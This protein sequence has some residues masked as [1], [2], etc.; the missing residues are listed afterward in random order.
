MNIIPAIDM[1]NGKCVRLYKGDYDQ[2]T[3]YGEDPVAMAK[4]F[5]AVGAKVLHLVDLDAAREQGNNRQTIK[6]I[7]ENVN[8]VVEVG[9]GIRKESDVK[10]L[11]AA[12][13]KRLIL[14]TI[15]VKS[16][17]L[18]K[19]WI[20]KY[21]QVDF[22]AGIDALNGEVKVAGWEKGSG[23]QDIVLAKVVQ[24]MGCKGIVY[25]NIAKDGTLEGP[26][27]ARTA[28]IANACN[29]PVIISGGVSCLNDIKNAA[30]ANVEGFWG[31]ITGK[32]IYEGR[33]SLKE[34][35]AGYQSE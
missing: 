16:P 31:V 14:G 28:E 35:I 7:C 25:T 6:K 8:M 4:E 3:I 13:V 21:P 11:I 15:L 10:E 33:L 29:L 1:I 24:E 18:V 26:D 22:I 5:E 32:A 20:Q 27:L 17:D 23:L 34:A 12:G 9:G 2:C 19:T 30:E